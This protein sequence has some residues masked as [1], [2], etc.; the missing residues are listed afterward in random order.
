MVMESISGQM[1]SSMKELGKITKNMA[2]VSS[3]GSMALAS[4]REILRQMNGM[5]MEHTSGS[6]VQ[7]LIEAP[8]ETV[9]KMVWVM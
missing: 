3:G 7:S 6:S 1:G 9:S 5:D 8:G 2:K 4:T